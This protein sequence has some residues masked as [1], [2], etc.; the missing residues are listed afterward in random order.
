M[1]FR[2]KSKTK[3]DDWWSAPLQVP[4]DNGLDTGARWRAARRMRWFVTGCV[5]LCPVLA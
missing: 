5:R 2:R 3:N 1:A 4:T